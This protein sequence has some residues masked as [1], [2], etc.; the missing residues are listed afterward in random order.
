MKR[1]KDEFEKLNFILEFKL[2]ETN[3]ILGPKNRCIQMN[4]VKLAN[5]SIIYFTST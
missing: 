5:V 2:R 1:T 3:D 4:E